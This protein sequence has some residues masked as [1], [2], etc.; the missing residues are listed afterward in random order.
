MTA[1]D[2]AEA[3]ANAR[4]FASYQVGMCLKFVRAE[5]WEI[6]SLYGDA[7][8][9]WDGALYRHPG[10]RHPPPGAPCFYAGGD[11]GH[12]VTATDQDRMRSTDAP[13][14][15]RVS[16][17]PLGWPDAQWGTDYLGW[18]EDLNGVRLPLDTDNGDDMNQQDEITEWSPDE[19]STGQTT[20]GKTLNQA[21]GY[22]EDTFERV[23]RLEN[24]MEKVL[25]KLD[26]LLDR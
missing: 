26:N 12:V 22:S 8:D 5:A 24:Q 13:S 21:R 1:A 10:D 2:G 19:G 25:N 11:F 7:I 14:S 9:A 18:T 17:Q 15:G 16:E 23:K 3:V 20:I 6:G 4:R